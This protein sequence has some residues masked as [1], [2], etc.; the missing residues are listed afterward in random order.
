VKPFAVG[1]ITLTILLGA[2]IAFGIIR[3]SFFRGFLIFGLLGAV[4]GRI[5]EL[6]EK[7]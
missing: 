7:K 1:V 4:A 2:S 3:G 5:A 6:T